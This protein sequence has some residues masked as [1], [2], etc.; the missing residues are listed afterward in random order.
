MQRGFCLHAPNRDSRAQENK[1]S[2]K[3]HQMH[4]TCDVLGISPSL[5]HCLRWA[6]GISAGT[7]EGHLSMAS[8]SCEITRATSQG[9][10]IIPPFIMHSLCRALPECC[11][12]LTSAGGLN[13][14]PHLTEAETRTEK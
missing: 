13:Y 7:A 11:V 5:P 14:H 8:P 2:S 9:L 10:V 3:G 6:P 12:D 4:H 1:R